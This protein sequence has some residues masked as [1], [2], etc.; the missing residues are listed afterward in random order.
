MAQRKKVGE[1]FVE[2]GADIGPLEKGLKKGKA[3]TAA[4]TKSMQADATKMGAVIGSVMA[5]AALAVGAFAVKAVRDFAAL[6]RVYDQNARSLQKLGYS[7]AEGRRLVENYADSIEALTEFSDEEAATSFNALLRI[8]KDVNASMQLN[9]LAM[10]KV[11]R[12]GGNLADVAEMLALAY[13]GNERGLSQ[14]SRELGIVGPEAKSTEKVFGELERRYKGA[15]METTTLWGELKKL[16]NELGNV[17][18]K[19]GGGMAPAVM[20]ASRQLRGLLGNKDVQLSNTIDGLTAKLKYL[21]AVASSPG[22]NTNLLYLGNAIGK[23]LYDEIKNAESQLAVAMANRAALRGEN[24]GP[25]KKLN[26]APSQSAQ[27]EADAKATAHAK[28]RA[29]LLS[30]EIDLRN[31]L[32]EQQVAYAQAQEA[33]AEQFTGPMA[34]SMQ[35][36]FEAAIQGYKT[37]NDMGEAVAKSI[38]KAFIGMYATV[39]EQQAAM[40][41][42][43][44]MGTSLNPFTALASPGM[45]ARATLLATAAGG[46]RAVAANMAEGGIV[47][48]RPGGTVVR[49]GERG[50]DEM[51]VPARKMGAMG[52]GLQVG[53]VQLVYNGVKGAEDA[54]S[55]GRAKAASNDILARLDKANQQ[56]GQRTIRGGS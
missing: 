2:V 14:L 1:A 23:D 56:R 51:V 21:K 50:D 32:V 26:P 3:S 41:F 54:M 43:E 45:F 49:L 13:Q 16:G 15:A 6:D 7:Y 33:I 20:A 17:S 52:G 53:T 35:Q 29:Q 44:A 40:A 25:G 36:F 27:D 55:S 8:T 37:L 19:A 18:E 42:A 48:A 12:D 46:L 47:K 4:A 31:Q 24:G 28:E 22:D 5:G 34:S 39:L 10:D 11:A 9:G 38:A 30:D